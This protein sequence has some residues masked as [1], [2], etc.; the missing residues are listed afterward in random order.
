MDGQRLSLG[1]SAVSARVSGGLSAAALCLGA[2]LAYQILAPVPPIRVVA[3]RTAA[4]PEIARPVPVYQPPPEQD[5][6]VINMRP[7]FD[8]ARQ[9]VAESAQ[10]GQTT[11][12]PPDVSLV[13]V[14]IGPQK[15]VAL[16]KPANTALATS[17]VVGQIVEGW[18]LVRIEA[19]LVVFHAN[20]T[21]VTVRLRAATGLVSS[22]PGRPPQAVPGPAPGR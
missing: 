11:L 6:A 9:P 3:R 12:P 8:P 4:Q 21:D 2:V 1:G 18:Q 5:F 19:G 16:L 7:V 20:A 10:S 15:S 22:V 17:A 13:G 14:V